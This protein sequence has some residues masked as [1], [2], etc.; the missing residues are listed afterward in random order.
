MFIPAKRT[1]ENV[2][3]WSI[4]YFCFLAALASAV[5]TATEGLGVV[6]VVYSVCIA[7][8]FVVLGLFA[9]N[10]KTYSIFY[11]ILSLAVNT[12][13]LPPMFFICGGFNSGMPFYLLTSVLI[14]SLI[15][16]FKYRAIVL[17]YT[18][19]LYEVIFGVVWTHPEYV[20]VI[21]P[22]TEIVDV[23][24][25]FVIMSAL[26]FMIITYLLKTYY[27]ERDEK[28]ALISQ[29]NFYSTHDPLTGLL[30]RRY[31]IDYICSNLWQ[32]RKGYYLMMYDVD[33]FK[34]LN[35]SKGHVFGDSVLVK[36]AEVAKLHRKSEKGEVSVRYGG[37]EFIQV[38]AADSMEEAVRRA[39]ALREAVADL[40]FEDAP[41]VRVTF[42]AGLVDCSNAEFETYGKML[43]C[44]DGLLYL[45]K[46]R[47]RNRVIER[48]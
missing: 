31:L 18:L 38:F 27:K 45:A 13:I 22:H 23:M 16:R 2:I 34:K 25:S 12:F 14:L 1:F 46:E 40:I 30:N 24:V 48:E 33:K 11:I 35:D 44:V 17:F 29:L 15:Q 21:D 36:I 3:F 9:R 10:A 37:E 28:D 8:F 26:I 47:G 32:H 20:P 4:L 41:E 5:F 19:V 6:S 43:H 39:N 7:I 42:S